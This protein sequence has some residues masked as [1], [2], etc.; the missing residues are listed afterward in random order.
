MIAM[1]HIAEYKGRVMRRSTRIIT[2]YFSWSQIVR[3]F[4]AI[5]LVDPDA[6]LLLK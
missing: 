2:A 4:E 1:G 5:V 3:D 6:A